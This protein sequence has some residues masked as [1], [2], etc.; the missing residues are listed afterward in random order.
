[1]VKQAYYLGGVSPSGFCTKFTEQIKS[2]GFYTYILK[3]GPGTG[4]STLMKKIADAMSDR[5]VS[6]YYCSSDTRSLD[7]VV[8]EDKK[9]IVVDGTAPHVFEAYYPGASQEVINLGEYW[10]G[11]KLR[12]NSD[13][14]HS[15]LDENLKY[16]SRVRCFVKAMAS[17]NGDIYAIGEDALNRE[18]LDGYISRLLRKAA[19]K[20]QSEG[21]GRIS[22]R[23]LS[24]F[25]TENYSTM[26]LG[27][28]YSVYLLRDD[29]FAGSD[30][31]LRAVADYL[32][33][34]G[35]EVTVSECTIHHTPV[36]EHLLC[37]S[38]GIAF[39]SSNFLNRLENPSAAVVNF[40]RFY[41]K[42][43]LSGRKQRLSFDRKAVL[44][45]SEEA[46]DTLGT[47]LAVHDELEKNYVNAIDFEKLGKFSDRFIEK[48]RDYA[49]N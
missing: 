24:A 8:I 33:N 7:A 36:Y 38:A 44:E 3:G 19:G 14:I 5:P 35:H 46:A 43:I 40:G 41:D 42:E 26:P 27:G 1:M 17:L 21:K 18:K 6:L 37:E 11:E 20:R 16:H 34:Q 13:T 12:L 2:P 23:Q 10:D 45:L 9:V 47:A 32:V 49:V 39:M 29:C 4:K 28:D 30:Y 22:F 48:L 15:Q 25:T 31:F